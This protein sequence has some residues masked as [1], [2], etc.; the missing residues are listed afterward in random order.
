MT[1]YLDYY[2]TVLKKVSFDKYLFYKEYHKAIRDLNALE[3]RNLNNW[4]RLSGFDN[5]LAEQ[6]NSHLIQN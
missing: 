5:I 2:K 6:M 1:T 3:I 4:I